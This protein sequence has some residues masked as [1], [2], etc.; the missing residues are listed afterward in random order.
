MFVFLSSLLVE[1]CSESSCTKNAECY[2][3]SKY[4]NACR[5]KKGFID[6]GINCDT[7]NTIFTSELRLNQTFTESLNNPNSVEYRNLAEQI[8][9]ALTTEIRKRS[10][11]PNFVGC[12]VTGFINGSVLAKYI[13][14]FQLE[15]SK[16]VNASKLS[17]VLRAAI[18]N[19]SLAI[20]VLSI[21]PIVATGTLI[22]MNVEKV[23]G[24]SMP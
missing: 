17:Q 6:N 21:K 4:S 23:S 12:Q 10:E 7:G 20:P 11:F 3:S 14:I 19:G 18:Q 24:G 9:N 16:T 22:I 5:C 8:Q 15:G 13:L 2:R 1:K